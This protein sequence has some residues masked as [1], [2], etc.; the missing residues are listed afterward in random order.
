MSL[1]VTLLFIFVSVAALPNKLAGLAP[2][3]LSRI[4]GNMAKLAN[5]TASLSDSGWSLY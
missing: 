1:T 2:L 5:V 4:Y 3:V